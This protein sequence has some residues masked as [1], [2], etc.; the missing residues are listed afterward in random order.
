MADAAALPNPPRIWYQSMAP[1]GHLANYTAALARHARRACSPGVEVVFNGASESLYGER[2][3]AELFRYPIAKH[4]LQQEVLGFAQRAEREGFDAFVLGS[5]SEPFLP[6]LRSL[7]DIPVVSM[8]EATLLIGCS[9]AE[10]FAL[11][12]LGAPNVIRVRKLV[13]R[14][15]LQARVSGVHGFAVQTDEAELNAAFDAPADIIARFTAVAEQAVAAGADVVVPA[16]G[17]LNEVLHANGV[18]TIA[19]ATILDC[20]GAALLYAE[21]MI[22]LRSRLAT[23]A[24]RRWSYARP[25]PELL[26]ELQARART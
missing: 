16:E 9:L 3:P 7:L 12:T 11:I 15:G 24:G 2:T 23:G 1:I 10:Q 13:A 4:L 18:K 6:E 21:M 20:V 22:A 17:V 14:H 19:G 8:P 26:A 5:F 25:S